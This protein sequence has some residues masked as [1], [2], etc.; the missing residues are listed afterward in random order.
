MKPL[1]LGDMARTA[2]IQRQSVRA[3]QEIAVLQQELAT[4]RA[5]SSKGRSGAEIALISGLER[6]RAS[7]DALM[8]N[9]AMVGSVLD[10]Q[11]RAL[12]AI[13]ATIEP[14]MEELGQPEFLRADSALSGAAARSEDALRDVV[15]ILNSAVAGR[16]IF[17]GSAHDAPALVE[18]DTLLDALV[19]QIP[20]GADRDSV[21]QV[22]SDWFA[23]GG[24]FDDAGY[25]GGPA[26]AAAVPLG[27]GAG[28]RLDLTA[29]HGAFRDLLANLAGAALIR[30]GVLAGEPAQQRELLAQTGQQ[31]TQTHAGIGQVQ[32]LIGMRQAQLD[33]A[34]ARLAAAKSATDIALSELR[35]VDPFKTASELQAGIARLEQIYLVTARLSRLSL[36]EYL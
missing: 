29:Q 23:P 25:Q 34:T 22:V 32:T 16:S 36:S 18:A 30:R 4:G 2:Q 7:H 10:G 13:I 28:L 11:E 35:G 17:A 24:G 1:A 20:P 33:T 26:A 6:A 27:E 12:A 21:M 19:A 15:A 9:A 14:R 3:R 5:A 8:A 31:L